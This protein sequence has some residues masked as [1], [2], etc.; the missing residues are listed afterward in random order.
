TPSAGVYRN[1]MVLDGHTLQMDYRQKIGRKAGHCGLGMLG[2]DAQQK[3]Y[4]FNW[5]SNGGGG[6][7][8]SFGSWKGQKLVLEHGDA[9][10]RHRY[11]YAF[12]SPDRF[13]FKGEISHDGV[14]WNAWMEGTYVR[15][16]EGK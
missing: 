13:R 2:Y 6:S 3:L 5:F 7:M 4:T 15:R 12:S 9:M 11:T 14:H 1:K 16:A 8:P 10:G